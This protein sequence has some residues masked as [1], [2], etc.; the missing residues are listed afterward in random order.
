V[1][2]LFR[3]QARQFSE[4]KNQTFLN[5]LFTRRQIH[6]ENVFVITRRQLQC[7][8][9]LICKLNEHR[10][11]H[12]DLNLGNILYKNSDDSD[13]DGVLDFALTDFG[14]SLLYEDDNKTEFVEAVSQTDKNLH[15]FDK[16]ILI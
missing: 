12:G 6:T 16:K 14:F 13:N 9:N 7:L 10:I 15:W 3:S 11:F 2:D 5:Q 1:A 8:Y 4:C